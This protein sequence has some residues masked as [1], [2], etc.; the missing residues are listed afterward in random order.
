MINNCE[1]IMKFVFVPS[2]YNIL[3]VEDSKSVNKI[4][5]K[6]FST[7]GFNCFSSFTLE[8]AKKI[9]E[10]QNIHYLMLDI[11]LPDG[12]GYELITKLENTPEKI[13]VLTH[14]KDKQFRDVAYQKGVIDFISKDKNFFYEINQI[15]NS[16]QQLEKNKLKTILIVDDSFIIQEQLKD[17]LKNR[18][19]NV[20]IASSTKEA[21]TILDSKLIDLMLLDIELNGE[22]GIEFLK[23]NKLDIIFTKNIPVLILSG[24][25]DASIVR[26]GLKA[27]ARD[28][29]KKPYVAEEIVLKVDTW[30]DYKR[31]EDELKCS[32]QLLN[33]YKDTVD[34]S[35]IVS[36]ANPKGIITFVNDKFCNLSGFTRDELIGKNH[37]IV[38]HPD[39]SEDIFKEIWHTIKDLKH[40]WTGKVKNRKK[41]GSYY[42]VDSII[43]PI[44]DV[45]GNIIEYIGLR[46]DIT[47]HEKVKSYFK[48]LLQTTTSD[49]SHSMK[50][51]KEYEDAINK[52]NILSRSD[53][54]G[55]ITY[56][57]QKFIE[58]SGYSK[59]ELLGKNHN[60]VRHPDTPKEIFS[61][62]WNT[63]KNGEAFSGVIKNKS[64][65]NEPYWVDTTIVPIKNEFDE[66]VEYM[67]IRHDLTELFNLHKE[68]N[69]T[70]KEMVYKMGEV[71]ESR[72]KETG[73]HVKRVAN[74]SK[75]L[76]LLY[77]LSEYD[78]NILFT[79]SPMHDIGKVGIEDIILNKPGKLTH[80]EF[81]I[82]KAHSQIGYDVL[83]G[84]NREVLKA[85]A[86][87]A[88]QHHEKYNG[89][90]Y[91]Q[92][93][94]GEDIHIYGRITSIADVFD[95][96]GSNRCY[97]KAWNDDDIFKLLIDGRGEQ[98]DPKLIDL[99]LENKDVF[100]EIRNKYKD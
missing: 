75:E 60:I 49:L 9:L 12:N 97:K 100:L 83:K 38:R 77:G 45:N 31:R 39:M 36:I 63:I 88:H 55:K 5:T 33:E 7:L 28:V 14:E 74:Y 41:D 69:D 15:S 94:K 27:G 19:Y 42:W 62:L 85:A 56:V 51:S 44:I 54:N 25:N 84:S 58:V 8:D 22:N 53:K 4:L 50:L 82:M 13:F 66:V 37:N 95:A 29:I 16:I 98:F 18:H 91:P 35:S 21:L 70:Q 61:E 17:L 11:N 68:I 90:G 3:I 43:K 86:I 78:A 46:K 93:L 73:N 2:T 89:Q 6:T 72:S 57:N 30:I 79:A 65:N 80:D 76:A 67:A 71:G 92:G 59:E 20:E 23:T 34:E 64:K 26:D 24:C 32:T 1:A 96:L 48:N 47:E 81:E 10:T 40:S 87:V 52:S 99:F